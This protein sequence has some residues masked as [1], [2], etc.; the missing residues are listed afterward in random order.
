M[1][2]TS[3]LTVDLFGFQSA[4]IAKSSEGCHN[5]PIKLTTAVLIVFAHLMLKVESGMILMVFTAC[6]IAGKFPS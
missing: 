5:H 3:H 4:A 1:E 6:G 2:R